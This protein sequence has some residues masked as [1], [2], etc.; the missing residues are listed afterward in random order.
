MAISRRAFLT[1]GVLAALAL[2]GR[3]AGWPG[4]C[5]HRSVQRLRA[6]LAPAPIYAIAARLASGM[7]QAL[8]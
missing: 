8:A 1:S 6:R 5:D 7:A 3:G 4:Q 2:A